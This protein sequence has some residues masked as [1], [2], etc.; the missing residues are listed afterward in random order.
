[1]AVYCGSSNH[2]HGRY[3]EAARHVGRVLAG[4]G[5]TVVYGAGNVG[6]MGAVADGALEQGGHVMGVIPEK[7]RAKEL[8]HG[9][10][11][12]LIV[13]DSMHSRKTIMAALSDAFL[14]LPG[15]FGTLDELFEAVT[16][17]QLGYHEKPVGL[18]D[19]GGY[20][21]H[22]LAFLDHARDEGFVREMH[23]EL[24]AA[25]ADT[26]ALLERLATMEIPSFE[27]WIERP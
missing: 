9:D 25:D 27:R 1:M 15:G 22:L 17:T 3:F 24:I 23:R 4:R 14:V 21:A 7:L 2:V 13:V 18:L 8:A 12:E 11:G 6:L 16:W 26:E 5:V 20:F 19:V 10:I